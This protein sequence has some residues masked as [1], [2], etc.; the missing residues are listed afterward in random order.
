MEATQSILVGI[1]ES[2]PPTRL[3][4]GVTS[5]AAGG[6]QSRLRKVF[7]ERQPSQPTSDKQTRPTNP[8]REEEVFTADAAAASPNQVSREQ[9]QVQETGAFSQPQAEADLAQ[10][11]VSNSE[12]ELVGNQ[13]DSQSGQQAA[14]NAGPPGETVP[15][16]LAMAI[17]P[18]QEVEAGTVP[19]P[20]VRQPLTPPQGSQ[21]PPPEGEKPTG[22]TVQ[23]AAAKSGTLP[24]VQ[25]PTEKPDRS[26]ESGKRELPVVVTGKSAGED[27]KS[28]AP[29]LDLKRLMT[30]ES[31]RWQGHKADGAE[32]T[33]S[34]LPREEGTENNMFSSG[35]R[36]PSDLQRP[37]LELLT[38]GS[39]RN[40]PVNPREVLEQIVQKAELLLKSNASEMKID[41]KPEFL[42]KMTIRIAVEE[43]VLT[44]RF[45][46][47]SQQV[48]QMLEANMSSLR[49]TLEAQGVRVEKTEVN[50][51]LDNH[52]NGEP[53]GRQEWQQPSHG[54]RISIGAEDLFSGDTFLPDFE[55]EFSPVNRFYTDSTMEFLV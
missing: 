36:T 34:N 48:R 22:I 17:L 46:A 1:K 37:S 13:V 20:P 44:A 3:K 11:P 30:L 21:N 14:V 33:G 32:V 29:G 10:L 42:G 28:A 7:Q 27:T 5:S 15:S 50:V 52:G 45:T 40:L 6:F 12:G 49:Q 51:Y 23:D 38:Q 41:L 39:D 31:Q 16:N 55:E 18:P 8:G 43:G 53:N 2:R 4:T 9:P 47:E 35:L 25:I 19:A 54:S 24:P 26:R